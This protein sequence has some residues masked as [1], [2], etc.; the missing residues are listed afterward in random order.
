MA[1][2]CKPDKGRFMIYYLCM[3][4]INSYFAGISLQNAENMLI[5]H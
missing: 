5:L 2:G 4:M 1:V 3:C